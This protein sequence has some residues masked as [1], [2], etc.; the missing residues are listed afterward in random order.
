M[1]KLLLSL[2]FDCDISFYDQFEWSRSIMIYPF[3]LDPALS[4]LLPL[5]LNKSPWRGDRCVGT[6][7]TL[8]PQ[9]F[10]QRSSSFD[11]FSPG[12]LVQLS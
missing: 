3:Y 10:C 2:C 6:A 8:I 5:W 11:D 1:V 7:G 9:D 12:L 4:L